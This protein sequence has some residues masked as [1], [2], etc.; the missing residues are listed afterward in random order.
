MYFC[1]GNCISYYEKYFSFI[2]MMSSHFLSRPSFVICFC[3]EYTS[4]YDDN[5]FTLEEVE[6]LFRKKCLEFQQEHQKK[7][8]NKDLLNTLNG[9]LTFLKQK[10]NLMDVGKKQK[11]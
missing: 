1:I 7:R 2:L 4:S 9:E 6:I 10:I 11:S 8:P 3:I 5:E